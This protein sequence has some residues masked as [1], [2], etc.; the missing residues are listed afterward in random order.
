MR[1][2]PGIF[3]TLA[4]QALLVSVVPGGALI[5]FLHQTSAFQ[6]KA[7]D[8]DRLEGF[9]LAAGQAARAG[10]PLDQLVNELDPS[11]LGGRVSLVAPNGTLIAGPS[12][13]PIV[14][15]PVQVDGHTVATARLV[16]VS[17]FNDADRR[18]L[19]SQY[20]GIGVI[21]LALFAALLVAA[22]IFA[23]R[24]SGPQLEL[25]HLSRRVVHG[26]HE[27]DFEDSGPPETLA[28]M[29]NLRRIASQFSR[30]E[31]ARRT[32]L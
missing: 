12:L 1:L 9:A 19:A 14:E 26:D 2:F 8:R 31:T 13:A 25:Y 22:Y 6:V 10:R 3:S 30:L 4:A 27:V 24:W 11:R 23:R 18:Y 15:R 7:R 32:W 16:R 20:I 29:R 28:T 5:L 17:E 21:V